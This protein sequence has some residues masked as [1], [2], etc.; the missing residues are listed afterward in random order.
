MVEEGKMVWSQH[1]NHSCKMKKPLFLIHETTWLKIKYGRTFLNGDMR[2]K[3]IWVLRNGVKSKC[4]SKLASVS[5][6][7]PFVIYHEH[8]HDKPTTKIII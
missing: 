8:Y 2:E 5:F 1:H 7:L 6:F 4:K 3:C